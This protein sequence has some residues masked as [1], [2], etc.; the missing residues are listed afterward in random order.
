M[1]VV[2]KVDFLQRGELALYLQDLD[3][4]SARD[5]QHDLGS[6]RFGRHFGRSGLRSNPARLR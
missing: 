2:L 5:R 4:V 6:S 3:P 1:I